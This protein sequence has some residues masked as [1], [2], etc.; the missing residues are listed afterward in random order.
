M[1]EIKYE[2][3]VGEKQGRLAERPYRVG[4]DMPEV[5]SFCLVSGVHCDIESD[6]HRGYSWRQ[7][8]GYTDDKEFV[9]MQTHKESYACWPTV[10]RLV[11]CWFAEI[12][13]PI[14]REVQP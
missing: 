4:D 11:N 1:S 9:C 3:I 6:Q 10:E 13:H 14:A 2:P 12:P 5:G 7:V 8:I